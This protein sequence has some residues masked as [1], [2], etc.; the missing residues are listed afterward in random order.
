MNRES[1][2]LELNRLLEGELMALEYYRIHAEAIT[3]EQ[4]AAGIISI[5]PAEHAH[6]VTLTT[7]IAE[8]GGTAIR[9]GGEA[10][11]KGRHM[12]EASKAQGMLAMV[13]LELEQEQQAIR[14]YATTLAAVADDM[15][16]LD[17]LEEHL[18]D[19]MRHA[20]WLKQTLIRLRSEPS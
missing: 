18:F 10:S 5:I 11:L 8:L 3:D 12:G 7:R 14:D 2:I 6:A 9:P 16:T 4:V 13:K 15:V 19:E 20:K 17:L 1:V